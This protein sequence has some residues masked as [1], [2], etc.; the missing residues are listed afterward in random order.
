[1]KQLMISV[2]G[3]PLAKKRHR[4]VPFQQCLACQKKVQG[5]YRECPSCGGALRFLTN[6]SYSDSESVKYENLI[7]YCAKQAMQQQGI[8][9]FTGAIRVRMQ[10]IF[11]MPMSRVCKKHALPGQIIEC[12]DP[13]MAADEYRIEKNGCKKLHY[14]DHHT[15]RPDLDNL[16]KSLDG[17]NGIVFADDCIIAEATARKM[18]GAE[19]KAEIV[20]EEL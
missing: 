5:Q 10:F 15:Q 17:L 1:M 14:G 20:I 9:M 11:P 7:S 2:P 8:E 6:V 18:W 4:T 12:T 3:I 16:N 13:K 19:G